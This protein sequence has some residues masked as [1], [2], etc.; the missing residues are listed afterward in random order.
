MLLEISKR[1]NIIIINLDIVDFDKIMR[2]TI[3]E[4]Q[5]Q[6]YSHDTNNIISWVMSTDIYNVT[7][8]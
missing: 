2:C 1:K 5:V 3:L 4:V 8:V 7:D 6:V